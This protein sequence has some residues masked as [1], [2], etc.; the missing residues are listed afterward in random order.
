VKNKQSLLFILV[1]VACATLAIVVLRKYMG[2]PRETVPKPSGVKMLLAT[3]PI[4]YGED[5]VLNGK[6]ANVKF[7]TGWPEKLRPDGS[8]T[9]GEVLKERK[10]RAVADIVKH[11]PIVEAVV[12]DDE[13]FIPPDMTVQTLPVESRDIRISGVQPGMIVDIFRIENQIP[14]PFMQNVKVYAIG[15]LD[16][17]R[18][19]VK[20]KDPPPSVHILIKK[21]D[22]L[23]FMTA[24]A[25]KKLKV[26]EAADP[27]GEGPLLVDATVDDRMRRDEAKDLLA[28]AKSLMQDGNYE[29]ARQQFEKVAADYATLRDLSSDAKESA[30]ECTRRIADRLYGKAERAFTVDGNYPLALEFIDEIERTCPGAD[31][32]VRKARQLQ[33]SVQ[34]AVAANRALVR[35]QGMLADTQRAMG[36]GNLPRVAE[37]VA[38]VEA[39]DA[40]ALPKNADVKSPAEA[41]AEF[42]KAL[43]D[44]ESRFKIDKAVVEA[45]VKQDNVAL[46]RQ[47]LDEMEAEFPAHPDMAG[48]EALVNGAGA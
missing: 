19:P 12:V 40:G 47:K 3:R 17:H 22:T 18:K 43:H 5:I 1:G 10:L 24:V 28:A 29:A 31:T 36:V 41:A 26:I 37:L 8:F 38:E 4:G 35:Y 13:D 39:F 46:A 23:A 11:Q 45:H 30:D 27:S 14:R 44:A 9:D 34:A 42:K 20:E 25:G 48:L 33:V 16:S 15:R 2:G 6:E 32:V 21:D 7:F